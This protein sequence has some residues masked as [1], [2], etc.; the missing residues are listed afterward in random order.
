[1]EMHTITI[2]VPAEYSFKRA[3]AAMTIDTTTINAD[4]WA[5]LAL[6]GLVQKI[7]DAAAGSKDDEA[8]AKKKMNAVYARLQEG[9]WT[10]RRASS[11]NDEHGEYRLF[12]R[13]ILRKSIAKNPVLKDA[14]KNV[15]SED[16]NNFIDH[17][18]DKLTDAQRESVITGAKN[19]LA[20]HLAKQKRLAKV[21][22]GA[23]EL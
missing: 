8:D 7:G 20:E 10:G 12:I 19:E 18:F 11:S 3:G 6:H 22:I 1:M 15:A 13:D 21:D 16:R 23:I 17:V 4:M 14:Y 9:E 5:E 2:T